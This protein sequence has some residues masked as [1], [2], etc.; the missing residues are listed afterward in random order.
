VRALCVG[1]LLVPMVGA[2]PAGAAPRSIDY[3]YIEANEGG[4]SGGHVALRFADETF[5][6]Q[7]ERGALIRLQ[8]DDAV[9]FDVRYALLGNRPIHE[10]RL[11]VSAD[12]YERLHDGFTRR[13]LVQ[14]AQ[15]EHLD[16]LQADVALFE[17]WARRASPRTATAAAFPVAA[18]GYFLPD[19][20]PTASIGDQH[21]TAGDDGS[22]ALATL[23]ARVAAQYGEPFIADR[24]AVLRAALTAWRPHAVD[25]LPPALG[26]DTYPVFAPTAATAY[27]EQLAGLTALEVLAQAP[28]LRPGTYRVATDLPP[29]DAHERERLAHIKD[30]LTAALVPLAASPR[31]DFGDALLLGMARIAAIEA[32]LATDRLVALDAFSPQAQAAPLP[33]SAE[34][35]AYFDALTAELRPGADRARQVLFSEDTFREADYA[36]LET[37]LNRLLEVEQARQ[38]STPVR[39]E[40]GLLTPRLPALRRDL[41]APPMSAAAA[42]AEL[43]TAQQAAFDYRTRLAALYGYNLLTR[44]CVSEIFATIDAALGSEQSGL[45]GIVRTDAT[46]NFIPFVSARAVA[47]N[48]PVIGARTQPSYRQLRRSADGDDGRTWRTALRE[49]NTLTATSYH[50]GPDDSAFVFFTDDAVALRPLL[51]AVNLLVGVADGMLGL[52]TWPADG[53]VRLRAGW[54]G[55]LFSLPE[56]AFVNIR[57]GSLAWIEPDVLHT[58]TTAPRSGLKGAASAAPYQK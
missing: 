33:G 48:Y 32:S 12:T 7:Q 23:R 27:A 14:A 51:G 13:L 39:M 43:R 24:I 53:G 8:R 21:Q 42:R 10:Q 26:L 38:A 30:L 6:F 56:L 35:S 5:H 49:S 15:Y 52:T 17:L 11:A 1:A 37:A 22:A 58:A 44:N 47:S 45:G 50:A 9:V 19:G 57:K 20:F 46:L 4:S 18:A 34:R 40:R 28:L 36:A 55:A 41:V 16:A 31:A 29:L 25:A 54:Y 2:V 3:L